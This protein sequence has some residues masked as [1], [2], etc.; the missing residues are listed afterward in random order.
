MNRCSNNLE[1]FPENKIAR[2]SRASAYMKLDRLEEA[3]ADFDRVIKS[4][5]EY[6]KAYHLRGLAHEKSGDNQAALK[7]FDRAIDFDPEFRSTVPS[8]IVGPIFTPTWATKIGP[9][10]TSRWSPI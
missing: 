7:D 9:R 5:P 4:H 2:L 8:T 6:A 10:K 1:I 3:Q